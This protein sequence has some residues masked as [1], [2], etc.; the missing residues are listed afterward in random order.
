MTK[1]IYVVTYLERQDY[2]D[3][4][5][6]VFTDLTEAVR[7]AKNLMIKF[8]IDFNKDFVDGTNINDLFWYVCNRERGAESEVYIEFQTANI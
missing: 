3:P 2:S 5:V 7:F 4:S 1:T 6:N 8:D